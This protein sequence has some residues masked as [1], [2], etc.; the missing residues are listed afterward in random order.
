VE[1]L[2]FFFHNG[3]L[4]KNRFVLGVDRYG[5]H[6]NS[7]ILGVNRYDTHR[8]RYEL[9]NIHSD[10]HRNRYEF[11]TNRYD[12][13]YNRYFFQLVETRCPLVI[14]YASFRSFPTENEQPAIQ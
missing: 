3:T 14:V 1:R 11:R 10:F 13:Q 12:F 5:I 6:K 9:S 7:F 4:K 8:N 2:F